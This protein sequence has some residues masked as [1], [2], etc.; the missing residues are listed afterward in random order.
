M[1][2]LFDQNLSYKLGA[3]LNELYPASTQVRLVGMDK[4]QDVV[5]WEYAR[6]HGFAIV[7][8][9][10]DYSDLSLLRGWPPKVVW[11]RCGNQ[12]T[13]II[14]NLLRSHHEAI[15][16]FELNHESGVLEIG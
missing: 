11:L 12:P 15:L 6:Q 7:T 2:L 8:Q 14:E 10:G 1:K 4:S 3:R 9:D 13:R 5:V 16:Q